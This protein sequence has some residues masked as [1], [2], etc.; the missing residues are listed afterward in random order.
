MREFSR[1]GHRKSLFLVSII[2]PI[3]LFTLLGYIYSNRV[4]TDIPVA[5]VD[6][7]QSDMSRLIVRSLSANRTISINR[8]LN[9]VDQIQDG[10]RKGD[11]QAAVYIPDGLERRIKS[12]EGGTVT[13]YENATN[14]ILGN[15]LL[16]SVVSTV[17]TISAGILVRKLEA[18]GLSNLQAMD[19]TIPLRLHVHSLFNP[20]YNYENFLV[21]GLLPA[22]LQMMVMLTAV[23]LV[24]TEFT[25]G[26]FSELA[27]ISGRN[28]IAVLT[29]KSIPYMLIFTSIVLGTIGI[30]FPLFG[31][32]VHGSLVILIGLFIYYNLAVFFLGFAVS[33][34]VHN[35][36]F[37]T[38]I[39]IFFSTPAFI[40]SG[41]TFP[42]WGMPKIHNIYAQILPSTHF[43]SGYMKLYMMGAPVIYVA[44]EFLK[45]SLFILPSIIF[46]YL[47]LKRRLKDIDNGVKTPWEDAR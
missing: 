47:Y 40:F 34:L 28:A 37:A 9:S 39:A 33:C 12:G 15:L 26:T 36:L 14:L 45:L 46:S 41:Y 30:L 13:F 21:P 10:F 23:L 24:S 3:I 8:S 18:G 25:D 29:G 1:I 5:V 4:V 35:R 11:I 38:E 7:D 6:A 20:A 17:R 42:L 22:L 27:Q 43:I 2:L 16:K 19:K 31:I 44:P 32:P